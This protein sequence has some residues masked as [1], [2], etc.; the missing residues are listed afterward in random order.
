MAQLP[1]VEPYLGITQ[2]GKA[3]LSI[4]ARWGDEGK[5]KG[6]HAL[7]GRLGIKRGVR[8]GG[9]G[10]SGHTVYPLPG[11]KLALNH[12]PCCA[13]H[14]DGIPC[15]GQGMVIDPKALFENEVNKLHEL[16]F[17][18]DPSLPLIDEL[19]H[20]VMP[21]H[22]ILDDPFGKIG[23]T[24]KGIG[25][26]YTDKYARR[27]IRMVD[28]LH[29]GTLQ[30]KVE[31]IV[32][33]HNI[34]FRHLELQEMEVNPIVDEYLEIGENLR[35]HIVDLSEHLLNALENNHDI[36]GEGHQGVEIGVQCIEYPYVTSCD[37][38]TGAFCTGTGIPP[39]YIG[40]I[41]GL[42]KAYDTSVGVRPGFLAKLEDTTG[43]KIRQR[44]GEFGATTGRPRDV[45]WL[46][47]ASTKNAV[48]RNGITGI[49]MAKLDVLTGFKEILT[50]VGYELDGEKIN[51][52][53]IDFAVRSRV[54]PIYEEHPGWEKDIVGIT[55]FVLLP[56]NA[57]RFIERLE[58]QF[59]VPIVAIGTGPE[60]E[61][62]IWRR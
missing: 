4:G 51:K 53:P 24:K 37:T 49:I 17:L 10:N 32:E 12:M 42:I 40:N 28:I 58:G 6:A 41:Y 18:Q 8:Y 52:L 21:W 60:P 27:G 35:P 15:L 25:P 30:T 31:E 16:G 1:K 38:T 54:T 22:F 7:V 29:A 47:V 56:K 14:K 48:W 57:R 2:H 33:Y 26:A 46:D 45:G 59:G 36:I 34:Y 3:H 5:G 13:A 61:D 43:E 55:N 44:G 20:I 23:S 39:K 19:A 62:F 50:C 11:V 9:G